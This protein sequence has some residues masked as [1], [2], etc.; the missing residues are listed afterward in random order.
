MSWTGKVG[1]THQNK[2]PLQLQ[3]RRNCTGRRL[4]LQKYKTGSLTYTKFCLTTNKKN[5][6]WQIESIN[7]IW[8]SILA[9]IFLFRFLGAG[10]LRDCLNGPNSS[11]LHVSPPSAVDLATPGWS[12]SGSAT[13]FALADGMTVGVMQGEMRNA[14][15]ALLCP[16][17]LLTL[18]YCALLC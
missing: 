6:Q 10:P 16:L 18:S 8:D 1:K 2:V 4:L 9:Q 12:E 7:K 11:S 3:W 5:Q 15:L 13:W 17:P 14:G